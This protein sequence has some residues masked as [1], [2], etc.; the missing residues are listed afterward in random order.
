MKVTTSS[1][2]VIS[3]GSSGAAVRE[4]QQLLKARG[5]N[6]GPIDGVYGPK[7]RAAVIAFQKANGLV[8]DGI[9]GPKTWAALRSTSTSAKS[10]SGGAQPMLQMGSKGSAVVTL[11]KALKAQGFN[12][13]AADG[14]FGP[15]TRAAV[16]AFQRARG[17]TVDGIV[18]P[19]TWKALGA[20]SAS[21]SKP[22]GSSKSSGSQP[23]LKYGSKGA[24]VVTLQKTLKARGFDPGPADGIFGANTRAAVLAFQASRGIAVDG[25]VGPQTWKELAKAGPVSGNPNIGGS[26][27]R[28]KILNLARS[29][30]GT[31]EYGNNGGPALKYQN[32]FGRGYEPWCADFVSW[33]FTNAGKP[34]ND[35]YCPSI[36]NKLKAMGHWKGKSNPQPGDMVIFDWD[37]G[38]ADHIG[39][40]E[41]VNPDGSIVTIEGNTT[42]PSTGQQGVWRRTRYLSQ[43]EGFGFP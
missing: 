14:I 10:S 33:V 3:S 6:P 24:A 2:P 29:Q 5:F 17:L 27:L 25:V 21:S 7:T 15:N 40:V 42:N 38:L 35:P 41:K 26:T 9:A 18:G 12:P 28:E 1:T 34:F 16:I 23:T 36:V 13:G 20:S 31:L 22:A 19:Q 37:G 4:L 39:I 32:F 8:A 11:Q 43:I 30:I